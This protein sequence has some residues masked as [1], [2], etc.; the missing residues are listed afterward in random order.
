MK[1]I[2]W[3]MR[4]VIGAVLLLLIGCVNFPREEDPA[5]IS[6]LTMGIVKK[7][8]IKGVTRQADI[9]RLFGSPNLVTK[10]K[11]N[12]EVWNYNRMSYQSKVGRDGGSIIFWSGSR[13]MSS[14]TTKSFDLI[15]IFDKN[16][17]VKDYSVI[18]AQY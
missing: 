9:L 18:S 15:L 17:I 8:I 3:G 13:A 1:E 4:L 7:R 12:D 16:D 5:Q 10:N 11:D 14:T 2:K 6:N